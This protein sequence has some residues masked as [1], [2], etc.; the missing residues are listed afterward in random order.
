MD[1]ARARAA[2]L[3]SL[4][5]LTLGEVKIVSEVI[6]QPMPMG[7]GGGGFAATIGDA[8]VVEDMQVQQSIVAGNTISEY[9]HADALQRCL[10]R[11]S[12]LPR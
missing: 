11:T 6:G 12:Q 4:S 3:A 10:G 9:G 7:L 2:S 1:D 8:H 5:N